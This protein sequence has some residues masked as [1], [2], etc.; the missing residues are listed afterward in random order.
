V[1]GKLGAAM[2][3]SAGEFKIHETQVTTVQVS[4]Q[5]PWSTPPR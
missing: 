2:L 1:E 4:R 5:N 3:G